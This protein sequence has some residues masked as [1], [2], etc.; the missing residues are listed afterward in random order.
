MSENGKQEFKRWE[1]EENRKRGEGG[2]VV[3]VG[4]QKRANS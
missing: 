3:K 4:R 2:G 1:G